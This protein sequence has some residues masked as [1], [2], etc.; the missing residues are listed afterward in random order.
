MNKIEIDRDEYIRRETADN[1]REGHGP[2][3]ARRDAVDAAR[4]VERGC[5][6]PVL[7]DDRDQD[8]R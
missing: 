4:R 3:L 8:L 5:G 2:Q 6:F 7:V 1:I